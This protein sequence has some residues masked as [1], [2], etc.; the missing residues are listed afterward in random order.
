MAEKI[1]I[2][3]GKLY[4]MEATDRVFPTG[5]ALEIEGNLA[6]EIKGG[7]VINYEKETYQAKADS[8]HIVG[9]YII[10]EKCSLKTGIMTWKLENVAKIAGVTVSG[11]TLKIGGKVSSKIPDYWVHFVHESEDGS[12]VTATILGNAV[13]GVELS[14]TNDNETTTDFE[15]ESIDMSDGAHAILEEVA[16][17]AG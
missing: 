14:F 17:P 9:N 5:T 7:A 3:S 10:S 6:G 11:S 2:G 16:A 8:G 1:I 12:K 13:S 4:I 15:F